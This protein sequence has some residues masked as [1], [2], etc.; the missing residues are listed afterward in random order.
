MPVCVCIRNFAGK[1]AC[2]LLLCRSA[3]ILAYTYVYMHILIYAYICIGMRLDMLQSIMK[4]YVI[5]K[6]IKT[7][8]L[9]YLRFDSC[10]DIGNAKHNA[11]LNCIFLNWNRDT[12]ICI[13]IH[14]LRQKQRHMDACNRR[15]VGLDIFINTL[16]W[17]IH[18][19]LYAK[20]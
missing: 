3:Y 4:I 16:Q 11:K 17:H 13:C 2:V 9:Y 10:L 6:R 7:D 1:H 15:L 14:L 12:R 19:Y 5:C 18:I 20:E 8:S